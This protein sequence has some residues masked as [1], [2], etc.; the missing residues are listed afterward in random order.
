[1]TALKHTR[2]FK[3]VV[4]LNTACVFMFGNRIF[5]R[6]SQ[7]MVSLADSQGKLSSNAG[8]TVCISLLCVSDLWSVEFV[9][10]V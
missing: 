8:Q 2:I 1:M 4:K 5:S 3:F 7:S 9:T 6:L 10:A